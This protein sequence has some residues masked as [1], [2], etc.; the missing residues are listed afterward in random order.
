[1][2]LR[3][4][5]FEYLKESTRGVGVAELS[6]T[7]TKQ[8]KL[9]GIEDVLHDHSK[10][11]SFFCDSYTDHD[12]FK[13]LR[14]LSNLYEEMAIAIKCNAVEEKMLK[15]YFRENFTGFFIENSGPSC[16]AFAMIPYTKAA[17]L[18][19]LPIQMSF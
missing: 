14:L 9:S 16:L 13:T 15:L 10:V 12:V 17:H 8:W 2:K 3:E 6:T 5:S 1:M 19:L 11:Q 7:L 4:K 18:G